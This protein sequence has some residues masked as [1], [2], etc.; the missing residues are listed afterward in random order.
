[1]R[2]Y[3]KDINRTANA[4]AEVIKKSDKFGTDERISKGAYDWL[5]FNGASL[6][7]LVE[8]LFDD[9]DKVKYYVF[10]EEF[11]LYGEYYMHIDFFPRM[12]DG[13]HRWP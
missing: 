11:K 10:I 4:I 12:N 6:A 1:M 7:S 2:V 5:K 9:D 3:Q 13:C 8:E